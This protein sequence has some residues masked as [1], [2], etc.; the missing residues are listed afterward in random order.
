[1]KS[2][3]KCI[4]HSFTK[5][6]A[7]RL[8][9]SRLHG[10]L[11]VFAK[12]LCLLAAG[13]A[14]ADFCFNLCDVASV[15]RSQTWRRKLTH[16]KN[17]NRPSTQQKK[18]GFPQNC[19]VC[20]MASHNA[21]CHWECCHS[22][23]CCSILSLRTTSFASRFPMATV[24][25]GE[26]WL[27]GHSPTFWV[28]DPLTTE[29][30]AEQLDASI[31]EWIPKS[32]ATELQLKPASNLGDR[33]GHTKSCIPILWTSWE[34]PWVFLIPEAPVWTGSKSLLSEFPTT[35][36]FPSLRE[37]GPTPSF[38]ASSNPN[39]CFQPSAHQ[40]NAR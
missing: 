7:T 20:L 5:H 2:N 36:K 31:L 30:L 35:N 26:R 9:L 19:L 18:T 13:V 27:K 33:T 17:F 14:S 12:T 25:L 22:S 3:P 10:T 15:A 34:K 32:M 38:V 37:A 8:L 39:T 16:K 28:R 23:F 4:T 1:M 40:R 24:V 11:E 6:R 21:A 29:S